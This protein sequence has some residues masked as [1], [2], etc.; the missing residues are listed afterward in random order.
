M[1]SYSQLR[2]KLGAWGLLPKSKLALVAWY[3]LALD[4]L[5]FVLQQLSRLFKLSFGDSLGG[6]VSFLSFWAILLFIVLAF[7]WLRVRMLWR[8]RNRLIVTYVF[9]GV[10]PVVLLVALALGSFYLFA[11]Q[12]A[13]FIV[14]SGLNTELRGLEAAN[15]AIAH[16]FASQLQRGEINNTAAF[17]SL[18]RSEKNWT[19]RQ[20]TVWVDKKLVLNAAPSGMVAAVPQLPAYLKSSFSEVARDQDELFLR[21]VA[22][23][24]VEGR[25]LVVLSSDPFDQRLLE[26]LAADLGQVA[27]YGNGL[28]LNKVEHP[29][30]NSGVRVSNEKAPI[31]MSVNKGD[32]EFVLDTGNGSLA[33]TYTAG[34]VPPPKQT[35]S[36]QVPSPPRSQWS[37]GAPATA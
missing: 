14:T 24:P 27:L 16:Q 13:T 23:I 34:T 37:T 33:P 26:D 12:F 11:G 2:L 5:L 36:R 28:K 15:F 20:V 17:D 25:T 32:N 4:V 7:R 3:V 29:Q 22:V 19:G 35:L 10:I 6:W 18:R 1:D 21:A 8:L 30:N 9:I 31:S